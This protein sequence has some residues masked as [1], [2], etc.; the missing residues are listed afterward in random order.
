M[1]QSSPVPKQGDLK[2]ER[3]AGKPARLFSASPAARISDVW[4]HLCVQIG[5]QASS[6]ALKAILPPGTPCSVAPHS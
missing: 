1:T 4:A 3:R 6:G 2:T 5:P